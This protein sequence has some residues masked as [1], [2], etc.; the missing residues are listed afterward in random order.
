MLAVLVGYL[1]LIILE[2]IGGAFLAAAFRGHTGGP[3]I[4]GGEFVTFVAGVLA[5]AITARM[6]PARP[7]THATVLGLTVV[8][9]TSI[10]AAISKPPP[11]AVFPHWYPYAAALLGGA[12]AF[13]GGALTNREPQPGA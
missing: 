8:T 13:I 11:G 1:A 10:V 9:V 4:V 5:G 12:G 7:L 2:L 6:A 3:L